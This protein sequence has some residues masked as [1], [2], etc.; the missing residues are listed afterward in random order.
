[1]DAASLLR[2]GLRTTDNNLATQDMNRTLSAIADFEYTHRLLTFGIGIPAPETAKAAGSITGRNKFLTTQ[3]N[4]EVLHILDGDVCDVM[5]KHDK[6]MLA[7]ELFPSNAQDKVTEQL[8]SNVS[9]ADL[10]NAH[11]AIQDCRSSLHGSVA[12]GLHAALLEYT[13]WSTLYAKRR[14]ESVV[15]ATGYGRH[16]AMV[17][18]QQVSEPYSLVDEFNAPIVQHL[19]NAGFYYLPAADF[20]LA[21]LYLR[22]CKDAISEFIYFESLFA[23]SFLVLFIVAIYFYFLRLLQQENRQIRKQG[24]LMLL[25]PTTAF[26]QHKQLKTFLQELVNINT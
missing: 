1:M 5:W 6:E 11:N 4:A 13:S 23:A 16:T 15:N 25:L 7:I 3:A 10:A 22:A 8:Y 21:D 18:W 24:T 9:W 19:R 20:E 12:H 2:K 26:Y 14:A 17:S